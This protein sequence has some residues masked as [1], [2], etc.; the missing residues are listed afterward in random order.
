MCFRSRKIVVN[1]ESQQAPQRRK[2]GCLG[3]CLIFFVVYFLCSALVGWL[4][5][6]ML[7]SSKVEQKK[8]TYY[9]L[10]IKIFR[11]DVEI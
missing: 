9:I 1:A 2:I 6:D 8:K 11:K 10:N 7:G 3:G 5:G 4:M